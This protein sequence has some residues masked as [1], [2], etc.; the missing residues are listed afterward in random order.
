MSDLAQQ[1]NDLIPKSLDDIIR[2]NRDQ[3]ELCLAT[4]AEIMALHDEIRPGP[5]KDWMEDWRFI[6]LHVMSTRDAQVMLL[7]HTS[8][9]HARITSVVRQIDLD[10]QLV[11]TNSGSLYRLGRPGEGEPPFYHLAMVCAAFHSWG[12]GRHLGVPHFFY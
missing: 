11:V 8:I 10:R 1:I 4:D 3:A 5:V 7:G 12:F 6:T 9:G 2:Q